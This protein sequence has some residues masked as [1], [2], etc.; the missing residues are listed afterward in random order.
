MADY[1]IRIADTTGRLLLLPWNGRVATGKG[2]CQVQEILVG[3]LVIRPIPSPKNES[4]HFDCISY[5][6]HVT[7]GEARLGNYMIQNKVA[8][9]PLWVKPPCVLS[10]GLWWSQGHDP[11][12]GQSDM[13]VWCLGKY[14]GWFY[15]YKANFQGA[16]STPARYVAS[17]SVSRDGA[18]TVTT[19]GNGSP[20]PINPS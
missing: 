16:S 5:D 18:V 8:A 1:L 12:P 3:H 15:M 10:L 7:S 17:V 14:C 11:Y 9:F 2:P 6:V 13:Q 19:D 4:P 20:F